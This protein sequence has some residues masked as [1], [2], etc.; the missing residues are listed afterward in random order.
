MTHRTAT[1]TR[2]TIVARPT[3]MRPRSPPITTH[4]VRAPVSAAGRICQC[5]FHSFYITKTISRI[6]GISF[7]KTVQLNHGQNQQ[8]TFQKLTTNSSSGLIIKAT[9]GLSR[10]RQF[11]TPTLMMQAEY[12]CMSV[13]LCVRIIILVRNDF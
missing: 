5:Y 7:A 9:Q 4:P 8:L 10:F 1:V 2:V 6:V 11:L 12:V 13:C 3:A